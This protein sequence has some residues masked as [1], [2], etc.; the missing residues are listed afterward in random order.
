[1]RCTDNAVNQ[2]LTRA[3]LRL[4]KRRR[5]QRRNALLASCLFCLLLAVGSMLYYFIFRSHEISF[6]DPYDINHE[7]YGVLNLPS[8]TSGRAEP[9]TA[10][11]CVTAD[12]VNFDG[13]S[14]SYAEAGALMDLSEHKVLFASNIHERL[15]PAS[16]T[17][18]MTALIAL[19]YG[20]L[21]DVITVD[22]IA[23]DI[24]PESSVAYLEYGDQYTLRQLIYG[25]LIASGNDA[26]NAIAYHVGGS[27][28]NFVSM[29]NSEAYA[30]GATNTHFT[31]AHGLQDES[32][33]TTPYDIYLMFRE[34]MQYDVFA[35]AINQQVYV[36]TYTA[37]D[38]E[39]YE[40]TWTSTSHYFTGEAVPPENITVFGGKTGTTDEAGACLSLLSKDVYGNSYFSVIMDAQ[41]KDDL[42]E[43]MNELLSIINKK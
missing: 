8:M 13:I 6:E 24:D 1:M 14:L 25:L 22:E 10:D 19:K 41:T 16:L 36:V 17:K 2:P 28:E 31:N 32:H 7:I 15:Y 27:I 42:Y 30:I 20:N 40:R 9:F 38:G 18:I 34:A 35:D 37:A 11:L 26:G 4:Q 3:Q 23:L 21:D 33:Y 5:R 39:Q 29:M 43:E 12:D